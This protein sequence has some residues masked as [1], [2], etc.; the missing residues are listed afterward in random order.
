MQGQGHGTEKARGGG[1]QS[2]LRGRREARGLQ[3]ADLRGA[4]GKEI[5]GDGGRQTA[6]DSADNCEG[7]SGDEKTGEN[8]PRISTA[9]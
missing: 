9:N 4:R 1:V 2:V 5:E 3:Q 6:W 7:V 8:F